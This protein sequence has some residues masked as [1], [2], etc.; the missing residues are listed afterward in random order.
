M[1]SLLPYFLRITTL[2]LK[3]TSPSLQLQEFCVLMLLPGSIV[4]INLFCEIMTKKL[5][6]L[7]D[8][9][10]KIGADVTLVALPW[11]LTFYIG[12]VPWEVCFRVLDCFFAEGP[13]ILLQ[14]RPSLPSTSV[15]CPDRS[16]YRDCLSLIM[17]DSVLALFST[18]NSKHQPF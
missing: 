13:N 18:L 17:M 12:Y 3:H 11:F 7:Y 5:P 1:A 16:F 8:H 14:V 9:L 4:D 10:N 15:L 2:P 6:A